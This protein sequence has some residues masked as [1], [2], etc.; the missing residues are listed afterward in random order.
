MK[1]GSD[2]NTQMLWEA[3]FTTPV[4]S[5]QYTLVKQL[6]NLQVVYMIHHLGQMINCNWSL[7]SFESAQSWKKHIGW[8][9]AFWHST[10]HVLAQ[11]LEELYPNVKLT[12][13]PAIE[14]GFY[15]DVDPEDESISDKDFKKLESK[16]LEIARGKHEFSLRPVSKADALVKY[17][18][19]NNSFKVELIENL[20]DGEI[21]FCD[22]DD[23]WV[24][25]KL[26]IQVSALEI[27]PR[28]AII[29]T[30]HVIWQSKHLPVRWPL[31]QWSQDNFKLESI[32]KSLVS[33]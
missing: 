16:F 13:G 32:N 8:D 12:I 5:P 24:P 30:D 14:N 22:H 27:F 25:E 9:K 15:Y 33:L 7:E 26:E 17:K 2:I 3:N 31:F 21:T 29:H 10:S 20:N 1:P 28:A 19:E 4:H 18:E 6:S 23:F 11:A